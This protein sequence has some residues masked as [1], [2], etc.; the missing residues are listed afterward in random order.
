MMQK[1]DWV[2][3]GSRHRSH[4]SA[5]KYVH[6]VMWHVFERA[7]AIDEIQLCQPCRI[8]YGPTWYRTGSAVHV[9]ISLR[10]EKR[11]SGV[12]KHRRKLP[13]GRGI[14]VPIRQGKAV[15]TRHSAAYALKPV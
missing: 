11:A 12:A 14:V 7:A 1:K 13:L 10:N 6:H 15:V 3:S 8:I 2:L 4:P 5:R 9:R